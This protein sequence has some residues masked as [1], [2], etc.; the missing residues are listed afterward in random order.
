VFVIASTIPLA[1]PCRAQ[2]QEARPP[3]NTKLI[4]GLLELPSIFRPNESEVPADAEILAGG[5][6]I[7]AYSKRSI[8]SSI[9]A[10]IQKPED[11]GTK[12]DPYKRACAVVYDALDDWYLIGLNPYGAKLKGWIQVENSS[13][14]QRLDSLI[15]VADNSCYV[16]PDWDGELWTTPGDRSKVRLL[17]SPGTR[18]FTVLDTK[19][20]FEELWLEVEFSERV[21]CDWKE[22]PPVLAKGWIRAYSKTGKLQVWFHPRLDCD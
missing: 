9:V 4:F 12:E 11:L 6:S 15:M 18:D 14:F 13:A 19:G 10:V 21:S 17:G 22:H 5:S 3:G 16:T 2:K 7:R 8:E 1:V 20:F